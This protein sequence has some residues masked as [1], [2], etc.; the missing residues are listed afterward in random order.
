MGCIHS[1]GRIKERGPGTD[2]GGT[3]NKADLQVHP[4]I[5]QLAEVKA[6][7]KVALLFENL[8]EILPFH[9]LSLGENAS[10][11]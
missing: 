9:H 10:G 3:P 4:E 7:K 5:F 11:V 8:A 6:T 2:P 1:C